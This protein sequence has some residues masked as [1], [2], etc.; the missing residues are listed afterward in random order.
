MEITALMFAWSILLAGRVFHAQR[1][2]AVPSSDPCWS[3]AILGVSNAEMLDERSWR[4][5]GG[6]S[7]LYYLITGWS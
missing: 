1:R 5:A 2:S 3:A 6:A 4:G 7:V